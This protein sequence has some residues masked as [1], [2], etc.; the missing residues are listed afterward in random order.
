MAMK[1]DPPE[2][3]DATPAPAAPTPPRPRGKVFDVMRPGRAPASPTSRPVVIGHKASAQAAQLKV[4]GIGESKNEDGMF[5]THKKVEVKPVHDMAATE[6]APKV[7]V[8]Q[9]EQ[10]LDPADAVV[11][12]PAAEDA[13]ALAEAAAA[14]ETP[15]S[16][17]PSA[18]GPATA[19]PAEADKFDEAALDPE[20]AAPAPSAENRPAPAPLP[21]SEHDPVHDIAPPD[22]DGQVVVSHHTTEPR[23]T[24]RLIGLILLMVFFALVVF[25]IL[26]DAG[27]FD[28][29]G[30]P[31]T[32]FF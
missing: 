9:D 7:A 6:S 29:S 13:P 16:T 3:P 26:L 21:E 24:G 18:P 27:V 28:I 11:D 4:S 15:A 22:L 2:T 5:D 23:G 20:P 17:P 10:A 8:V 1:T 30:V 31:H 32:N 12:A 19:T 14:A 25:N